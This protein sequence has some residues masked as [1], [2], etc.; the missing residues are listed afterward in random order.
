M[1]F[2]NLYKKMG[3]TRI[4]KTPVGGWVGHVMRMDERVSKKAIKGQIEGRRPVGRP[5]GRWLDVADR[6]AM[7][8]LK[9]RKW[10][11]MA[12]DRDAWR[13]RIE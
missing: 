5:R 8:M 1:K 9:C 10:R 7:R 2:E 6:D 12:E 4:E 11:R 3:L 13:R